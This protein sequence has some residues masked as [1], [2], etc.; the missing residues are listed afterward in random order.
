M[1]SYD[2]EVADNSEDTGGGFGRPRGQAQH[3]RLRLIFQL[4]ADFQS[5]LE[6]IDAIADIASDLGDLKPPNVSHCLRCS[7]NGVVNRLI[8]SFRTRANDLGKAVCAV[9][10]QSLL[11]CAMPAH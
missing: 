11:V 2:L 3:R 4:E 9:C 5:Y 8:D 7:R 1:T 6:V 10:H